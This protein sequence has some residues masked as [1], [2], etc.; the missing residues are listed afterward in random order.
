MLKSSTATRA[1]YE[2]DFELRY[3]VHL[4][5]SS[6][7]STLHVTAPQST[8]PPPATSLLQFTAALHSYIRLPPGISPST[9]HVGPLDGLHYIDKVSGGT[10]HVESN[11]EVL[12]DGP[13]GEV[14]RV[15]YGA[16]DVLSM[17]WEGGGMQVTKAGFPDVVVRLPLAPF[18]RSDWTFR[19]LTLCD[20]RSG[21]LERRRQRRWRIWRKEETIISSVS[22]RKLALHSALDTDALE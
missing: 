12:I 5:T 9:T 21:T 16:Q 3:T 2:P 15:Y 4:T 8:T 7:K 6:L 11:K 1:L 13:G 18:L 10:K 17:R 22:V 19:L 14:D 20:D